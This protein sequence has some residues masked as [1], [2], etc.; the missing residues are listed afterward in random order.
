MLN[1]GQLDEF[2]EPKPVWRP[3]F[4]HVRGVVGKY[5]LRNELQMRALAARFIDDL[6]RVI[7]TA[8]ALHLA[9][10]TGVGLFRRRGAAAR[11]FAHFLLSD[12]IANAHDHLSHITLMRSVRKCG[13]SA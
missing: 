1:E 9:P 2:K 8:A 3:S 11:C 4:W 5:A 13:L 10:E 12:S 7:E 6:L